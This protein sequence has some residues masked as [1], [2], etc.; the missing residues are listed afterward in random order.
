MNI[1][2]V[3]ELKHELNYYVDGITDEQINTLIEV[4]VR[5]QISSL[6]LTDTNNSNARFTKK[7]MLKLTRDLTAIFAAK[8][9][10][11]FVEGYNQGIGF[12]KDAA[13][14]DYYGDE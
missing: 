1:V 11:A 10:E 7:D 6:R 9:C 14:K 2:D 13:E 12:A 8:T 4:I 5:G 3:E